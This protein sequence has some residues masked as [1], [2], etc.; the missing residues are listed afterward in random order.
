ML[1]SWLYL[2]NAVIRQQGWVEAISAGVRGRASL[3]AGRESW[4][5]W[6]KHSS[7]LAAITIRVGCPLLA[8]QE[9]VKENRAA[10]RGMLVGFC[11][12][13]V[14]LAATAVRIGQPTV[15]A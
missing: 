12:T 14:G 7:A 2:R 1:A 5:G 8:R 6:Q 4:C 11:E 15:P 10:G 13:V 3:I 9:F